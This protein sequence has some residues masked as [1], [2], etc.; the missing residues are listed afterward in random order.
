MAQ[1][2]AAP[3][4]VLGL[5]ACGAAPAPASSVARVA[6]TDTTALDA[7]ATDATTTDARP[8]PPIPLASITSI[9]LVAA[10]DGAHVDHCRFIA[11]GGSVRGWSCGTPDG[12]LALPLSADVSEHLTALLSRVDAWGTPLAPDV[13]AA[14]GTVAV[15]VCEGGRAAACRIERYGPTDEPEARAALREGA[16]QAA[17]ESLA[18]LRTRG[19]TCSGCR[20]GEYCEEH[21]RCAGLG[22]DKRAAL[23]AEKNCA[24]VPE[25][26]ARRPS[27][28]SCESEYQC[29]SGHCDGTTA[30]HG[31][32]R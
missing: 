19:Q 24:V 28:S 7:A 4:V 15:G 21:Y 29:V 5:A 14:P 32:C 25:C 16:M 2:F 17:Q 3:G 27:A 11:P 31:R 23:G 6:P 9:E 20:D 13:P 12:E 18:L 1:R 26:F 30:V 10:P 22:P 8:A